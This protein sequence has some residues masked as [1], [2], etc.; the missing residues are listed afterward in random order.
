MD[1]LRV[2]LQNDFIPGVDLFLGKDLMPGEEID[3]FFGDKLWQSIRKRFQG[4]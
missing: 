3:I 4:P 1:C 2:V